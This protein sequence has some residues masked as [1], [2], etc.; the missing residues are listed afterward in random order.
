MGE[1]DHD[2]ADVSLGATAETKKNQGERM[3]GCGFAG[4]LVGDR[5]PYLCV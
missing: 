5:D 4:C 3:D 2:T 1:H